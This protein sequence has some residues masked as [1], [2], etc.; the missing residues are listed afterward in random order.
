V[1]E[2]E[3]AILAEQALDQIPSEFMDRLED[4]TIVIAERSPLG[5][6]VLADY[7]GRPI[8]NCCPR[9]VTLY[10]QAIMGAVHRGKVSAEEIVGE[11]VRHELGHALG[12]GHEIMGESIKI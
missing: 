4:V 11:A 9:T 10:L 5:T 7:R 1:S 6:Q 3:L 8:C 12:L 2:D